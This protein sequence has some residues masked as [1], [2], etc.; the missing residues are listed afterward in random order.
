MIPALATFEGNIGMYIRMGLYFSGRNLIKT[1]LRLLLLAVI[2]LLT[3]Y[4][5]IALLLLPGVY[6]DLV[7]TGFQKLIDRFMKDNGIAP[8]TAEEPKNEVSENK[9]GPVMPSIDLD[10]EL[11]GTEAGQNE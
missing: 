4:Y 10:R 3:D 5:P 2:V 7:S 11:S 1:I 9:E 8:E 6:M